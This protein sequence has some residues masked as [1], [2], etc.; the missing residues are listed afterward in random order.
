MT[1]RELQSRAEEI[2]GRQPS[3]SVFL[4]HEG[5]T[6]WRLYRGMREDIEAPTAELA[7]E[8]LLSYVNATPDTD[9]EVGT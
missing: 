4:S 3:V 8:T 6:K 1:L 7:L 2:D 5:R 9:A